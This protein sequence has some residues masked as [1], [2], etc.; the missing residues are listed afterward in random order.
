M[1][2]Y[3]LH[4]KLGEGGYSS[5]YKCTDNLGIR[6]ACKVLPKGNNKRWK[7]ENEI[8]AM[9]ELSFSSKVVKLVEACENDEN[10]YIIQELCRGGTV[11]DYMERTSKHDKTFSENTVASFLRGVLRGLC[12]MHSVGVIH[13]DV[14]A[15]NV[16][17]GDTSED[18][19][20]KI[21]DLGTSLILDS[22]YAIASKRELV[23]TPWFMAPES[24]RCQWYFQSDIWS[25]G[26]FAYHLLTGEMPFNDKKHPHNPTVA[27]IWRSILKD[28][29][30]YE[31]EIWEGV[32]EDAKDFVKTCLIK[33]YQGRP[34]ARECLLHP[35]LLKTDCH[36]RFKGDAL[37]C[38]P[39]K[40]ESS[41]LMKAQTYQDVL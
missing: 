41:C 18:A 6:Y 40:F 17:V 38:Q 33:D 29:P 28:T 3:I 20:V 11:K 26:V 13:R 10:Y 35:W 12:H 1:K 30:C 5:V 27:A 9:K 37:A 34:T 39:F 15:G 32:S 19:D 21:G 22:D 7:V 23:G 14:K 31:G 36:D 25:V 4:Q 24:L 2:Q 8:C 16:L